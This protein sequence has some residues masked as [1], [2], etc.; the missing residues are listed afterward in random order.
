MVSDVIIATA[1]YGLAL[2]ERL[3]QRMPH[4]LRDGL[5]FEFR[6]VESYP[7]THVL[8]SYRAVG[9]AGQEILVYHIASA[10]TEIIHTSIEAEW[11][12]SHLLREGRNLSS[13]QRR[14]M[15]PQIM[16]I[17]AGADASPRHEVLSELMEYLAAYS[18]IHLEGFASFRLKEYH[19]HVVTVTSEVIAGWNAEQAYEDFVELLRCFMIMQE[20]RIER[21][22]VLVRRNGRFRLVDETGST[23][24]NGHLEGYVTDLTEGKVDYADLLMSVLV[25]L[26]PLVVRCHFEAELPVMTLLKDV[27]GERVTFCKGRHFRRHKCVRG[28]GRSLNNK[29]G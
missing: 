5:Q 3:E 1:S 12:Q 6:E 25:T 7:E 10:L 22:D 9:E 28:G 13:M 29:N 16:E 26:A 27:F 19:R 21:I 17:V 18:H 4:M 2:L 24:D 15:I 23:V 8:C 14:R 11:V 20:S